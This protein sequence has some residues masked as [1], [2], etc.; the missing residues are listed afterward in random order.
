LGDVREVLVDEAR[1]AVTDIE[2]H[3]GGIL[4]VG[5]TT[6]LIPVSA[7]RG[8]GPDLVTADMPPQPVEGTNPGTS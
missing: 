4:G 2:A 5:G 6:V 7:I 1:G 8:I 3:Q